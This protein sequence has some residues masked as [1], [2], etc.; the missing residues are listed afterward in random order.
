MQARIR[1]SND[2][3]T[4]SLDRLKRRL[5][6]LGVAVMEHPFRSF[7][8][9]FPLALELLNCFSVFVTICRSCCFGGSRKKGT[10]FLHNCPHLHE[11]LHQ[12]ECLGHN[13]LKTYE[14]HELSDGSL[15]FDIELEA[16]YPWGLCQA[17][18]KAAKA[19]FSDMN[20]EVI[21]TAPGSRGSWILGKLLASAKH[22]HEAGVLQEVLPELDALVQNLSRGSEMEHPK[23]FLNKA[24]FRGSDVRLLIQTL[25]EVSRQQI[26][27]PA[28]IWGWKCVQSYQWQESQHIGVLELIVFLVY[29]GKACCETFFQHTRAFHIFDSHVCSCVIAKGCSSSQVSNR[30]LRRYCA[31]ALA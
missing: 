20:L 21:P 30:P 13:F 27:Y 23:A 18:A 26:P 7:G 25:V 3:F 5:K 17:Y 10:A 6:S 29:F 19:Y 22:L 11:A 15:R 2:M 4:F 1:R 16:E 8:W 24:D 14:M 28:L 9:Q 12:P 31:L